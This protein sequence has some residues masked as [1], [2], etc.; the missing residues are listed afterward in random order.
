LLLAADVQRYL[1]DLRAAAT[2]NGFRPGDDMIDLT[3]HNPGALFA[4]GAQSLGRAWIIGGYPGSR[5]LAVRMLGTV[6]CEKLVQAWVLLEEG[7]P[8]EISVAVLNDFGLDASRDYDRVEPI[9][10]AALD[11]NPS[12]SQVLLRPRPDNI[13]ICK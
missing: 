3:G 1:T 2:R 11:G 6:P 12:V 8:R 13:K 10:S 5:D 7:G 9:I 4:V